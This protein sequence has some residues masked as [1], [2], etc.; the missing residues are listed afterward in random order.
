[1]KEN[2]TYQLLAMFLFYESATSDPTFCR[3]DDRY[4]EVGRCF[5]EVRSDVARRKPRSATAIEANSVLLTQLRR[6]RRGGDAIVA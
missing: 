5:L 6:R 2:K 1:M 3:I 4:P